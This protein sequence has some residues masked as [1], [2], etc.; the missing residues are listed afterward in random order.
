MYVDGTTATTAYQ[1]T[2][3]LVATTAIPQTTTINTTATETLV[4]HS[5]SGINI[6]YVAIS[7]IEDTI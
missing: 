7:F 3:S 6:L 1:S 4:I 5:P 2:T